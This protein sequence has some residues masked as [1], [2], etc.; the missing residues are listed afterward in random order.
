MGQLALPASGAVYADTS[1]IIYTVEKHIDYLAL[2]RPLWV[3]MDKEQIEVF[4]SELTLLETLVGPLKSGN[5]ILAKNYDDFLT[6][7]KIQLLPISAKI[8]REA[9]SLRATTNLKTPDAIHAAAAMNAGCVQFITNDANFRRIS[10]LSV[11]V[12]KDI[13]STP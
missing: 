10:S 3:A 6:T 4:S 11:I 9:A 12:L 1:P 13:L 8:L 5:N 2:L 7:T